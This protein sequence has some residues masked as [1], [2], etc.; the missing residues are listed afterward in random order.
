MSEKSSN[1]P[2]CYIMQRIE[3]RVVKPSKAGEVERWVVKCSVAVK[4]GGGCLMSLP[5]VHPARDTTK[6]SDGKLSVDGSRMP[7][8]VTSRGCTGP[9]NMLFGRR[10]RSGGR[11]GGG[12]D[13]ARYRALRR[14]LR[15]G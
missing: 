6:S 15:S 4:I 12:W 14:Q 9:N 13:S 2:R 1:I 8:T 3:G 5:T 10:S 7:W 11:R